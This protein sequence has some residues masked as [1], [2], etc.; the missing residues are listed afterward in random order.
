MRIFL[1][2][3]TGALG[4]RLAPMLLAAGHQVTGTTRTPAKAEAL[5]AAGVEPVVVDGLDREATVAAVAAARPDAI[6]HQL[7]GLANIDNLRDFDR[8]FELTNRLRTE[9]TD[10]LLAGAR[11]AGTR[12]FV[13][14][15]YAGWPYA[16]A[17][18]R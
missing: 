16:A 11:A 8:A 15:S 13:A 12:R 14:Q 18:A 5:R 3:A 10:N 17:A 4:S 2:G 1:A 7:T 9:G 6:V